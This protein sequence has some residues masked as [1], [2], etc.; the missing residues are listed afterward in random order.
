VY[1]C[2]AQDK[3][4][5]D[6]QKQDE[7]KSDQDNKRDDDADEEDNVS[8]IS[9]IIP[10]EMADE[11]IQQ[12]EIEVMAVEECLRESRQCER[13]YT[14]YCNCEDCKAEE[15]TFKFSRLYR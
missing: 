8:D 15:E 5:E 7:T 11:I 9:D 1:A 4:D 12:A 10:P 3:D 2:T 6:K 13:R 14:G